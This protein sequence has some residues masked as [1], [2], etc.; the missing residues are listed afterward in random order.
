[1]VVV[2]RGGITEPGVLT[3]ARYADGAAKWAIWRSRADPNHCPKAR[4]PQ[5]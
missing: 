1:M 5:L 2:D 3:R 4:R